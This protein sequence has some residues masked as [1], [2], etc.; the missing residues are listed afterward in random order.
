MALQL[1]KGSDFSKTDIEARL[2]PAEPIDRR[3]GNAA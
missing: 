2:E 1:F 3:V